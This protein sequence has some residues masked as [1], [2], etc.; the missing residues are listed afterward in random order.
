MA[1]CHSSAH[2]MSVSTLQSLS[3]TPSA[4]IGLLARSVHCW[5]NN[6]GK[7]VRAF[8]SNEQFLPQLAEREKPTV[9]RKGVGWQGFVSVSLST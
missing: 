5:A 9:R 4:G 8:S 7:Q 1:Q 2:K 6:T 3:V